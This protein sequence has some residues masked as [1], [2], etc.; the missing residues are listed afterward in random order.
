M[1][2]I[3]YSGGPSLIGYCAI[4]GEQEDEADDG[5]EATDERT[6]RRDPEVRVPRVREVPLRWPSCT[7]TTLA[8]SPGSRSSTE[9]MVPP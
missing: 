2:S 8:A 5:H 9:V 6:D 3:A 1:A 4:T 7:V